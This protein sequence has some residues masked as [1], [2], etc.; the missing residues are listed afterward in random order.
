MDVD[1]FSEAVA[2]H[3]RDMERDRNDQGRLA[4]HWGRQLLELA[5]PDADRAKL[6]AAAEKRFS[7]M[8]PARRAALIEFTLGMRDEPPG[9]EGARRIDPSTIPPRR[10]GRKEQK[11][12]A[13]PTLT[14]EQRESVREMVRAALEANPRATPKTVYEQLERKGIRITYSG[15]RQT[16][17]RPAQR[18][19][20]ATMKAS[21]PRLLRKSAVAKQTPATSPSKNG[22]KAP[23]ADVEKARPQLPPPAPIFPE[24]IQFIPRLDGTAE[25]EIKSVLPHAVAL[26]VIAAAATEMAKQ[27][28]A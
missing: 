16:Y 6:E 27:E 13:R 9:G 12:M 23:P 21:A 5:G 19:V 25:I 11:A 28:A 18:E 22:T 14:P 10:A 24:G 7:R 1:L 17:W 26:R 15:F 4:R 3:L 2:T 20:A 8:E